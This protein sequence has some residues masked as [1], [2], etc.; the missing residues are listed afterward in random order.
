MSVTEF[1]TS[2]EGASFHLPKSAEAKHEKEYDDRIRDRIV[3]NLN[4]GAFMSAL[5][6]VRY[7]RPSKSV[8]EDPKIKKADQANAQDHY[9]YNPYSYI[10]A[11]GS[12]EA[13]QFFPKTM[14]KTLE[15]V[16]SV[17]INDDLTAQLYVKYLPGYADRAFA[18]DLLDLAVKNP[19]GA[20]T[21]IQM[22]GEDP[23]YPKF[24][25]A[26]TQ[27][28]Q[29]VKEAELGGFLKTNPHE[30]HPH[31]FTKEIA[32]SARV[33]GDAFVS[34][35]FAPLRKLGIEARY[36]IDA[37]VIIRQAIENS[38]KDLPTTE[39]VEPIPAL[40]QDLKAENNGE[41]K[42]S[43]LKETMH[44]L[45]ARYLALKF[46]GDLFGLEHLTSVGIAEVA[47]AIDEGVRKYKFVYQKD[48]PLYDSLYQ[49]FDELRES[50]RSPLEVYV[51]RD[52]VYAYLGRRAQDVARRRALGPEG[53]KKARQRGE[54][55]EIH[56]K[57]LV[58]PRHFQTEL[59]PGAK[60][61]LL[62][63]EGV[64]KEKD[65]IFFDTGFAGSIP[66]DMMRV[67]GF[68]SEE[69]E[70][71]IRLLSTNSPRRRAHRLKQDT[72]SHVITYI[73]ENAK[74][75][76]SATG[77]YYDKQ[78]KLRPI[79]EPTS[80]EEQFTFWMIRQA[81]VRHYYIKEQLAKRG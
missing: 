70:E 78:G 58:Y 1:F 80:P 55:L 57:Y 4:E 29:T 45:V 25:G 59:G 51:G 23:D 21:L 44:R 12:E 24:P 68:S 72:E 43:P 31:R 14:A 76:K 65:P 61:L 62:A 46:R 34:G 13:H 36:G 38:Y 74:S 77:L 67:M 47:G 81:I 3:G 56:P 9:T 7:E 11:L 49:E 41:V 75:E 17:I 20:R 48:I 52:G 69:I 63:Q 30:K 32:Q 10:G 71:R 26:R 60:L 53:R 39:L 66:E 19:A 22:E 54:I 6:T 2:S 35:D 37:A 40:R 28:E 16:R 42:I 79:A 15:T 27:A 64:A 50:G 18:A 5:D 8:A 33:L 73:E